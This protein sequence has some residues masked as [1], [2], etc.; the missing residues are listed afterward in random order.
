MASIQQ[1]SKIAS[2]QQLNKMASMKQLNKMVSFQQLS[3]IASIPQPNK[4]VPVLENFMSQPNT[5]PLAR[6]SSQ[7]NSSGQAS[8]VFTPSKK[9]IKL[10]YQK[11][12]KFGRSSAT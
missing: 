7:S 6:K 10:Q 9:N 12:A 5:L 8:I 1:P 4:M 2:I 11:T 3:K